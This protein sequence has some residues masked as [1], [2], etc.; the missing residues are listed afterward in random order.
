MAMHATTFFLLSNNRMLKYSLVL[1]G[2]S[3][4]NILDW[5]VLRSYK[6]Q[7]LFILFLNLEVKFMNFKSGIRLWC[8]EF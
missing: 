5:C 8:L 6:D 3:L 7:E 2:W 4:Q 1:S